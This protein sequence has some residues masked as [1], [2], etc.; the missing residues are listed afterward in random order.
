MAADPRGLASN[1]YRSFEHLISAGHE[2]AGHPKFTWLCAPVGLALNLDLRNQRAMD[3]ALVAADTA[4]KGGGLP[5]PEGVDSMMQ[6]MVPDVPRFVRKRVISTFGRWPMWSRACSPS[7][8]S[9][10]LPTVLATVRHCRRELDIAGS[11]Y[12]PDALEQLARR[13]LQA[14][15][16]VA[17]ASD[18]GSLRAQAISH[19]PPVFPLQRR[20][21]RRPAI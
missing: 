8:V 2:V 9:L 16:R 13:R 11:Q 17:A 18:E 14:L 7:S 5:A 20:Q 4:G 15:A 1:E 3:F 12:Q 6:D 21:P 10:A 19:P